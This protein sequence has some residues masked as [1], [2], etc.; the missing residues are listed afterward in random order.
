MLTLQSGT[1]V[2]CV[3]V[4][5]PGM[6]GM[7][8]FRGYL[9][10]GELLANELPYLGSREK[11][12]TVNETTANETRELTWSDRIDKMRYLPFTKLC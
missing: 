11:T 1:S 7:A 5:Y 8:A 6:I 9:E 3:T 10:Y 12:F 4:N 2:R